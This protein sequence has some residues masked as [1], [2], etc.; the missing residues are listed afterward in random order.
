MPILP[1]D[2]PAGFVP[3]HAVA[4]A[5]AG[6]AVAVSP[7]SPLPVTLRRASAAPAAAEGTL[8]VSGPSATFL[9][10]AERPV[11]VTLSGGW[12]GSVAVERSVDGG[13]SW[14]PLTAGGQPWAVFTAAANEAVA[15]E[16]EVGARYRL[17]FTR[18]SG[19]L[20]YRVAQ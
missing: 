11:W 8:G 6:G 18:A 17:A 4:F 7:S 3:E 9:A 16:S 19:T 12:T 5:D 1:I 2:T 15:M 10:E 14:A 20:G 13:A